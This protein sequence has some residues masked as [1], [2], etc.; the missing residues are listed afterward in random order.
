VTAHVQPLL[1]EL[2]AARARL[3]AIVRDLVGVL[4]SRR[5]CPTAALGPAAASVWTA[6][7]D[8]PAGGRT[9]ASRADARAP[10]GNALDETLLAE[11][12]AALDARARRPCGRSC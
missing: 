5:R 10:T 9:V 11:L 7:G 2:P 8:H 6:D 4:A 12:E 1:A 3:T